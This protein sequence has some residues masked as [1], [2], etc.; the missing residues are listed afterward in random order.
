[1]QLHLENLPEPLRHLS[2]VVMTAAVALALAVVMGFAATCASTIANNRSLSD[3]AY[4]MCLSNNSTQTL[5]TPGE[6]FDV[7]R[8]GC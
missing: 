1:M 3:V 4:N 8:L 6:P 5:G 7:S 2:Y